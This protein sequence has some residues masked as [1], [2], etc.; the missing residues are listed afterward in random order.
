MDLSKVKWAA[1]IA[2]V[3]GVGWSL[4]SPG[5]EWWFNKLK[6]YTPGQS[7]ENDV[8]NE[9][10]LSKFGGYLFQ[11]LRYEKAEEVFQL[12]IDRYPKGK[13]VYYNGYRLVKCHEKR[14]D[15]EGAV[16]LLVALIKANA[17]QFDDRVP[18][19]EILK[20]RTNKLIETHSLGEL[21]P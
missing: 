17:H 15:Y 8:V 21:I 10:S 18:E 11:T 5:T 4:S 14:E 9:A 20:L 13:N 19:V 2:V 1:I 7:A 6:A 16:G 12:S 3:A